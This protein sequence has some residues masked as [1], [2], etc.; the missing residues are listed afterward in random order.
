MFLFYYQF[1]WYMGNA[2]REPIVR[3]FVAGYEIVLGRNGY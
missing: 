2:Y 3:G 1:V